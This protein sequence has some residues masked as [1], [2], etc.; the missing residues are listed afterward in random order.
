MSD[1]AFRLSGSRVSA[2]ACRASVAFVWI[3]TGLAVFHPEY[4]RIGEESLEPFGL[5]A[6]VMYAT[7]AGEV[8]LGLAVLVGRAWAALA[9]VQYALI[10][11]FTVLLSVTQP[12]LWRH[13]LGV[14][15][16]NLA[17]LLLIAAARQDGSSRLAGISWR[18]MAAFWLVDGVLMG[19]FGAQGFV[20]ETTRWVAKATGW[21]EAALA[22]EV[23]FL[24]KLPLLNGLMVYLVLL[25]VLAVVATIE[26]PLLWVHPF[27]PLTKSVPVAV[28]TMW[29]R[30]RRLSEDLVPVETSFLSGIG[31][32]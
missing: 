25:A 28:A 21:V 19:F 14:L 5:P 32:T 6:E 26:E 29:L 2:F 13:P 11:G 3:W 4:R 12:M 8:A 27:G 1:P 22:I 7:C 20:P 16:K 17:L 24:R 15:S 9:M 23:L 31:K 10:V 30:Q 18:A